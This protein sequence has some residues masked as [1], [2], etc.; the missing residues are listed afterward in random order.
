MKEHEYFTCVKWTGNSGQGTR[1]Y[2][3]YERSHELI[4]E[5]KP[6]LL[7]S[8]DPNFRGDSKKLNPEELFLCSISSCHMLWYLHLCSDKGIV[9]VEYSDNAKGIMVESET[10]AGKFIRVE[11]FPSVLLE[12]DSDKELAFNLHQ[13]AHRY[14]FISNS[15]NF[16]VVI[17]PLI[18]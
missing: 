7:L 2:K 17:N 15:L 8:S 10:G 13:E 14:C 6:T 5:G 18:Q 12:K 4:V 11:L 1:S 9:V 3:S 16:D